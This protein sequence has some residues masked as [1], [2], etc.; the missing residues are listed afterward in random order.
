[1][2]LN[3]ESSATSNEVEPDSISFPMDICQPNLIFSCL[4]QAYDLNCNMKVKNYFGKR[5]NLIGSPLEVMMRVC[6]ILCVK[7]EEKQKSLL[8]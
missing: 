4:T 8:V 5:N 2:I 1:M 6:V 7:A 3:S